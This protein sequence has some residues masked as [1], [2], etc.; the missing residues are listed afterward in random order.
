VRANKNKSERSNKDLKNIK[1][2]RRKKG[3]GEQEKKL[4]IRIR[5]EK[6]K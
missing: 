1:K 5:E 2:G 3:N 4:K 6:Q